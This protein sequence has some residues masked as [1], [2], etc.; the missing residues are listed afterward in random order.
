M[1]FV[2][3]FDTQTS[4]SVPVFGTT[5]KIEKEEDERETEKKTRMNNVR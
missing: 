2:N 5:K 3:R 1:A 4:M